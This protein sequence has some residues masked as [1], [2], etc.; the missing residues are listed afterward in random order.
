MDSRSM[1]KW[2][3][4]AFLGLSLGFSGC[5]HRSSSTA[6]ASKPAAPALSAGPETT[7][8]FAG[9]GGPA[10]EESRII[11]LE[12]MPGNGAGAGAGPLAPEPFAFQQEEEPG[13]PQERGKSREKIRGGRDQGEDRK[14][15]RERGKRNSQPYDIPSLPNF[16]GPSMFIE[17]LPAYPG[18]EPSFPYPVIEMPPRKGYLI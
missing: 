11:C 5:A 2:G 3:M 15:P 9:Q 17:P 12:I 10:P 14:G 16:E 7:G 1:K 8:P 4:A 18:M 6:G 13:S